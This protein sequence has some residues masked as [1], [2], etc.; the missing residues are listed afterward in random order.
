MSGATQIIVQRL[1]YDEFETE[2]DELPMLADQDTPE[3]SVL[4]PYLAVA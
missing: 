4:I 1:V 2:Q 3:V